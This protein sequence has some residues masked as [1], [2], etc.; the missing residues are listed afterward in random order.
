M[1]YRLE[2]TL[3]VLLSIALYAGWWNFHHYVVELSRWRIGAWL[4]RQFQKPVAEVVLECI[5]ALYY[6]GIPFA[7]IIR[8]VALPRFIG[9]SHLDWVYGTGNAVALGLLF[10]VLLGLLQAYI[11]RAGRKKGVTLD[12]H[13]GFFQWGKEALFLQIHWAFYR[14]LVITWLGMHWGTLLGLLL[15]LAEWLLTPQGRQTF[16]NLQVTLRLVNV[17]GLAVTSAVI[18]LYSRNFLFTLLAH[19][20]IG[21]GLAQKSFQ[22]KNSM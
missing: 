2:F 16:Q 18:F 20:L 8:G 12:D 15:P 5:A 3:W 19:W 9:L 6:L 1:D 22:F 4:H 11:L 14:A 17:W 13:R 21:W 7:A 10:S